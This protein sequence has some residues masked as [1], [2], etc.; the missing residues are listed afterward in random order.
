MLFRLFLHRRVSLVYC[1]RRQFRWIRS[2][3]MWLILQNSQ[4]STVIKSKYIKLQFIILLCFDSLQTK[5][6]ECHCHRSNRR[7]CTGKRK[8]PEFKYSRERVMMETQE[9]CGSKQTTPLASISNLAIL[10]H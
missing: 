8:S 5:L 1:Q 6:L 3:R 9:S 2:Y 7:K 10:L 4:C